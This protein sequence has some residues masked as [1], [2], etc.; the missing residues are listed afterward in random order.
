MTVRENSHPLPSLAMRLIDALRVLHE[1]R[2]DR[3]IVITSMGTAREWMK[4]PEHPLDFIFVP[5]SM[6][7]ASALG[8]GMA[9]A[10]PDLR[11]I[12]CNGDGSTL[13]NLG[14]LVTI[15]A[16]APAN[17]TLLVFDNGV[18]EVTGAQQTPGSAGLRAGGDEIDFPAIARGSG[19]RNVHLF[20]DIESWRAGARR[21]L[22][23]PGPTFVLLRV[24]PIP[25]ARGPKFPGPGKERARQFL[26]NV[27]QAAKNAAAKSRP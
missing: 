11:V 15:T 18:Y 26:A 7:Q 23:E 8:L 12:A 10:Q 25:D 14:S 20:D 21:V 1:A 2:T 22:D 5:S 27:K 17:F 13:M 3:E 16:V 19:F 24:A 9:V 4:F 6:G